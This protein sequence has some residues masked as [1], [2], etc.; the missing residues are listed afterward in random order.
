MLKNIAAQ[1]LIALKYQ[2]KKKLIHCDLKPENIMLK[3][4]NRSL[5][6]VIDYGSSCF[7]NEQV[8]TYI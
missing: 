3:H 1:I 4:F 6:K 5:I 7:E 8:Y 2:K